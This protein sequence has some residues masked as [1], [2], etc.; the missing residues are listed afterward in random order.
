MYH[1]SCNE[2]ERVAAKRE[3][4]TFLNSN[5]A[6]LER[7]TIKEVGQHLQSLSTTN[8]LHLWISLERLCN[9]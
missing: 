5:D 2:V 4:I 8:E 6:T 7:E 3:R 9:K 1:R